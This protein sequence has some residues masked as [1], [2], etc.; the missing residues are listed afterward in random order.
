MIQRMAAADP[1]LV[2][3]QKHRGVLLTE[4]GQAIALEIIRHHRLLELFFHQNWAILG[5][6][7]MKRLTA[8]NM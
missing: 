1:P 7:F 6:K 8:W 4:P 2:E 3:Y 5:M